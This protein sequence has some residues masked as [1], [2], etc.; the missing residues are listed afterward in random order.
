MGEVL[1]D[2]LPIER[3]GTTIG[4]TMHPGGAP[5]NVAVGLSRL[6]KPTAFAGKASTDMFG[7]YLRS[8]AHSEGIDTRFLLLSDAP[9]TLAFVAIEAGEPAFA[10]Y[11]EGAAD[12]LLT[13]EEVPDALFDETALLHFGS[14][15][16]LRG[17]TPAAVLATVE[18]LKSRGEALLSFDPNVRAS[19]V[20]DER[21]YRD[22][23][24]R[25]FALADLVKLSAADISWL[26]PRQSVE[27]F[28]QE[29]SGRGAALVVVTQ[30]RQG[31]L[32]VRGAERQ[33]VPAFPVEVVDTVGAGD[34]FSSGL[35]AGLA[36]RGVTSRAALQQL[37]AGELEGVLRFASAVSAL[38]CTRA[39]ADPPR[40]AEV[41]EFL[42]GYGYGP[43]N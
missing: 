25:L 40:R 10:F 17:T 16:L 41:D 30:G 36:D 21:A 38:T 32:A 27:Q 23:L 9:T 1:V 13:P 29:L 24:D 43:A 11:G 12:T 42:Y 37:E 22:L 20:R 7:R 26:A 3:E 39:G 34:A 28:A 19:L 35:L 2:F 14:I 33:Q 15:S 5:F 18:R 8:H 31:V 6:G 4:F